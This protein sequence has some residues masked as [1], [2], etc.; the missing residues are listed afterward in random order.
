[1]RYFCLVLSLL[2]FSCG[3]VQ[4]LKYKPKEESSLKKK[5]KESWTDKLADKS[6]SEDGRNNP[7]DSD[8]SDS[9]VSGE[10]E[11]A[12]RKKEE[13]SVSKTDTEENHLVDDSNKK[14][15]SKGSKAK[16]HELSIKDFEIDESKEEKNTY[17]TYYY[18]ED[19]YKV[20]LALNSYKQLQKSLSERPKALVLSAK[21][22]RVV[23]DLVLDRRYSSLLQVPIFSY[24]ELLSSLANIYSAEGQK[25]LESFVKFKDFVGGFSSVKSAMKSKE[26][27]QKVEELSEQSRLCVNYKILLSAKNRTA[28]K[29]Y[30]FVT[31]FE[32]INDFNEYF[33]SLFV[34]ENN[35]FKTYKFVEFETYKQVKK[36][37]GYLRG[38]RKKLNKKTHAM[39]K[40]VSDYGEL[41]MR[42]DVQWGRQ[43]RIFNDI[44]KIRDGKLSAS[45]NEIKRL[46]DKYDST[47]RLLDD[48]SPDIKK[49][50]EGMEKYISK[51]VYRLNKR[52]RG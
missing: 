8:V 20:V 15:E 31:S 1:M 16:T 32:K 21:D 49:M 30:S 43:E 7:F 40:Y 46:Q 10:D 29:V 38:F 22:V 34:Y 27:W 48:M 51:F 45:R 5:S 28:P 13:S 4:S 12:P 3:D 36:K 24:D 6:G 25:E 19:S 23:Q 18:T 35:K 11:L 37:V 52:N 39:L 41:V 14:E 44:E 47:R 50:N 9:Q 26:F 42:Y 2:L 17:Y 33:D